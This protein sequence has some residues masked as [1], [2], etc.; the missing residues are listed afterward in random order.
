MPCKLLRLS[1]L[2]LTDGLINFLLPARERFATPMLYEFPH[3]GNHCLLKAASNTLLYPKW[4][5]FL[6]TVSCR[7]KGRTS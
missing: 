3:P 6:A 7:G 5:N 1:V 4:G 2:G